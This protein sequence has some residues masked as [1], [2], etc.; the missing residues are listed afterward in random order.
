MKVAAVIQARTSSTRLPNKILRPL[1]GRAVLGWVVRAAQSATQ[2]DEVV[3]ATSTDPSDD[4]VEEW[5]EPLGVSV[6]R[7]S[8]DD[9]LG[10]FVGVLDSHVPDAVVRLTADCPMLDPQVIDMAVATWRAN[11]RLDYVSSILHR[12]L[13]RGLDVEVVAAPALRR[14]DRLAT[15][16][17]RSHVTSYI[18]THPTE[19]D[20]LG[21]AF[22]PPADHFRVT[23]DT[24][25]D[26]RMLD[27]LAAG[28][29]DRPPT[30][31]EV[32][33][34]LE[35]HPDV[36]ALNAEVTQKALDEG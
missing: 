5:A 9:V 25:D 10:R 3:V 29:G 23:L 13:P 11:P 1:A 12:T 18:Y 20:I 7:G 28:L 8:L 15:D 6:V 22:T 32:T 26:A 21:L 30:W 34:W 27:A 14:V 35:A 33:A 2:V 4:P 31:R 17:H 24:E 19:F 16:F 36:A